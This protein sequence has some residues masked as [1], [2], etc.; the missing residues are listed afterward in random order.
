MK[1]KY[2]ISCLFYIVFTVIILQSCG[3]I[4]ESNLDNDKVELLAPADEVVLTS[5]Q[6]TFWWDYVEDATAYR[7]QVVKPNFDN[8]NNLIID[9]VLN[10]NQLMLSLDGGLYEWRVRGENSAFMTNF[11][12]F[13]FSIDSTASL[14]GADITVLQ[15]MNTF[16]SNSGNVQFNWQAIAGASQYRI[17]IA[18]PSFTLPYTVVIDQN[19]SN[20]A[21][22]FNGSE[23]TYAWRINAFNNSSASN[24]SEGSFKIDATKPP[25]VQMLLPVN[26]AVVSGQNINFQWEA[27]TEVN[28]Y[29]LN[30]MTDFNL[31]DTVLNQEVLNTQIQLTDFNQQDYFWNVVAV[32]ECGNRSNVTETRKFTKQ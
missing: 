2:F 32:D 27:V 16:C 6:V 5:S 11:S 12:T 29:E 30:L 10:R 15:P 14:N 20:N 8:V 9:T 7:L 31:Q 21:F 4:F 19:V 22:T 23:G 17:Q 26:N 3:V 13:S 28:K 25:T 1:I 24:I 18:Q